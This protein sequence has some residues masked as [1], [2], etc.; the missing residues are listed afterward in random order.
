MSRTP[1]GLL[2]LVMAAL[3]VTLITTGCGGGGGTQFTGTTAQLDVTS[4]IATVPADPSEAQ[5]ATLVYDGQTWK[6]ASGAVVTDPTSTLNRVINGYQSNANGS[7]NPQFHLAYV[8][9]YIWQPN[10]GWHWIYFAYDTGHPFGKFSNPQPHINVDRYWK[11]SDLRDDVDHNRN[12]KSVYDGH[13]TVY[14]DGGSICA[15]YLVSKNARGST[16]VMLDS[17]VKSDPAALA[18]IL[19]RLANAEW[20]AAADEPVIESLLIGAAL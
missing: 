2:I 12:W 6:D 9:L 10:W 14:R 20:L 19:A 1:V 16:G 5:H 13:F 3:A 7:V 17:C 18:V 15:Y 11:W 8:Y 4:P